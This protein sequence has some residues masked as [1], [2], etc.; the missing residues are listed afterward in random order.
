[1]HIMY[2]RLLFSLA[3]LSSVTHIR[4]HSGIKKVYRM[5]IYLIYLKKAKS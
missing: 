1:M 2:C 3:F 4:D 5:T